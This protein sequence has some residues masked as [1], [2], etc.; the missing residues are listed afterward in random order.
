MA[1]T[2]TAYYGGKV[3]GSNVSPTKSGEPSIGVKFTLTHVENEAGQW[4]E[5][6]EPIEAWCNLV[7]SDKI[8]EFTT[9]R[10]QALGFNGNIDDPQFTT[11]NVKVVE[12]Q[13]GQWTNYDPWFE[14]FGEGGKKQDL[15][16]AQKERMQ[17]LLADSGFTP[18]GGVSFP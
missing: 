13:S 4:T 5:L 7:F 15:S 17:R 3:T 9:Q 11:E 10:L 12:S 14:G 6:P 16:A 1:R 18:D 8:M 2:I